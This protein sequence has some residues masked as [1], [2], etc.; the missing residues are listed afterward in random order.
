MSRDV[1]SGESGKGKEAD[2]PSPKKLLG[3]HAD[4][5]DLRSTRVLPLIEE[6]LEQLD[7][8]RG[9]RRLA[10]HGLPRRVRAGHRAEMREAHGDRDG[11]EGAEALASHPREDLAG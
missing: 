7:S 1:A 9:Q 4:E 2:R 11:A 10:R 5:A 8:G 6:R 3:P